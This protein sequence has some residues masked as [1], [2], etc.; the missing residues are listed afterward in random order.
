[1]ADTDVL[2][3]TGAAGAGTAGGVTGF[4]AGLVRVTAGEGDGGSSGLVA[5]AAGAG[6]AP[7]D[8][9]RTAGCTES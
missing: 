6:A 8:G 4:A 5:D 7:G 9:V 2:F 1:L 3:A